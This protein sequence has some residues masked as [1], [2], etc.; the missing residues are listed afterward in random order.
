MRTWKGGHEALVFFAREIAALGED[1]EL[2][3]LLDWRARREKRMVYFALILQSPAKRAAGLV[4]GVGGG[5]FILGRHGR[6]ACLFWELSWLR[7]VGG[8]VE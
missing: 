8:V 5:S 4:G 2:G 7:E 3:V 1:E 6:W